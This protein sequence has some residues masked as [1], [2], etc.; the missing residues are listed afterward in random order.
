LASDKEIKLPVAVDVAD[1]LSP[2]IGGSLGIDDD[3]R[4]RDGGLGKKWCGGNGPAQKRE[5]K[6]DSERDPV[7]NVCD[8]VPIPPCRIENPGK[9]CDVAERW[10]GEALRI[11]SDLQ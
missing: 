7:W 5:E 1:G 9:T 6:D 11:S 8:D 3:V 2:R 10:T 4:K